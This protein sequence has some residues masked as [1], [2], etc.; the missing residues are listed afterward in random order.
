MKI[1]IPLSLCP[2]SKLIEKIKAQ[3]AEIEQLSKDRYAAVTELRRIKDALPDLIWIFMTN[4]SIQKR[5]QAE[6]DIRKLLSWS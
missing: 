4:S 3:D 1:K 5:L 2:K 6:S